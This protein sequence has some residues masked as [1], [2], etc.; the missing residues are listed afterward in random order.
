MSGESDDSDGES[1]AAIA[2]PTRCAARLSLRRLEP[3]GR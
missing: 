1:A 2:K 3:T